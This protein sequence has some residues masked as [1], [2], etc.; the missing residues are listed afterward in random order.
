MKAPKSHIEDKATDGMPFE[1]HV[2]CAKGK[3]GYEIIDGVMCKI[4]SEP[5][6]TKIDYPEGSAGRRLGRKMTVYTATVEKCI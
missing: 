4:M 6:E 3:G 1:A 5:K 2:G